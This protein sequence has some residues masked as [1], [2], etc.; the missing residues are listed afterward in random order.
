MQNTMESSGNLLLKRHNCALFI[1]ILLSLYGMRNIR[2]FSVL[3]DEIIDD[4]ETSLKNGSFSKA[5]DLKSIRG[6]IRY[7]VFNYK[8]V[9]DFHFTKLDRAKLIKVGNEA[10]EIFSALQSTDASRKRKRSSTPSK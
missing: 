4:I 8:K 3:N 6:R 7:L 2:D 5:I 1:R 10:A 9:E